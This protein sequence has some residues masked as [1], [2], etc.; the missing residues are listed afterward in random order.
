MR[1][2]LCGD[3]SCDKKSEKIRPIYGWGEFL[4]DYL[5]GIEVINAARGGRSSKS[6]LEEGA[7]Q[8]VL[9][10]LEPGDLMLIQ[11]G[12]NDFLWDS[13]KLY[14]NPRTT[15]PEYLMRYV[16][17][18]KERGAIPVLL[19]SVWI[20]RYHGEEPYDLFNGYNDAVRELAEKEKLPMIEVL[21][22]AMKKMSELP[23]DETARYFGVLPAGVYENFPNGLNDNNHNVRKGAEF[24]A[25]I[26][27]DGLKA[28]KLV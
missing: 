18:A 5:D 9:D 7:L 14:T 11:F 1:I 21:K 8:E 20:R 10:Q 28:L 2:F 13:E 16:N 3:S 12:G 27:A 19:T 4:A 25:R 17:G 15:Y 23:K 26:V 6:F 24:N 22:V